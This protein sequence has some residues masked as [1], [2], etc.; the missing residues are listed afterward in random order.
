[1]LERTVFLSGFEQIYSSCHNLPGHS[2]SGIR[3]CCRF[4][5]TGTIVGLS[6]KIFSMFKGMKSIISQK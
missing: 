2:F 6:P 3:Y 4:S 5:H 1:M